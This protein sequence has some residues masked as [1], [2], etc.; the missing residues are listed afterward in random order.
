MIAAE[1]GKTAEAAE[2]AAALKRLD[3]DWRA[4]ASFL[5]PLAS[6]RKLVAQ[7]AEKAGLPVCMTAAQAKGTNPDT[8]FEEC[9][10]ERARTAA[11]N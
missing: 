1:L 3:P 6:D 10:R 7:G 11:A 5:S 8:R 4:E 9:E 2:A